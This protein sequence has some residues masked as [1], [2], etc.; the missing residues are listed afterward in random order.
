MCANIAAGA[1]V[2]RIAPLAEASSTRLVG[3]SPSL[4]LPVP[5]PPPDLTG[6][7]AQIGLSAYSIG[8]RL[9]L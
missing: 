4:Y 3:E 7:A 6:A 9:R 8:I 2:I 5:T 1:R